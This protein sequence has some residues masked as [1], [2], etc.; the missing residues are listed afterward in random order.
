MAAAA[1][2]ALAC[3]GIAQAH[4]SIGMFDVSKGYWVKGAVVT[5]KPG[6]PHAMIELDAASA[7]GEVQRWT[8]EGPFPG[9]QRFQRQRKAVCDRAARGPGRRRKRPDGQ[10]V[11]IGPDVA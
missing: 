1:L 11:R 3:A 7:D 9:V 5:Y 6:A 4:H 8:I 2:A 10:T